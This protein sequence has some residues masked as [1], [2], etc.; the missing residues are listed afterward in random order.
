MTDKSAKPDRRSNLLTALAAMQAEQQKISI[1]ISAVAR[2][3]G[4]T[5]ALIHNTYP[6]V[7]ENIRS[8]TGHGNPPGD[9]PKNAEIQALRDANKRLVESNTR[10][11][12]DA[13]RLASTVQTLIDEVAVLRSTTA[14]NLIHLARQ[15]QPK[16][17]KTVTPATPFQAQPL[18]Y[19]SN[20]V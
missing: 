10:L 11:N 8:L 3:A 6:D 4:V 15:N 14:S 9:S 19:E 17:A 1:S 18:S 20:D 5:P 13:A 12:A 16:P 2:R 7:A